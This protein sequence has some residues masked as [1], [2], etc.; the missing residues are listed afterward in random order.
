M[1]VYSEL[2]DFLFPSA[3]KNVPDILAIGT[4]ESISERIEWEISIQEALGP[5]HLLLHSTTLGNIFLYYYI[6]AY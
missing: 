2:N 4:Q 3:I 6:T 1:F 5:S